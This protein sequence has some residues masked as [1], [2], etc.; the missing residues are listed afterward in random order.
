MALLVAFCALLAPNCSWGQAVQVGH[1]GIFDGLTIGVDKQTQTLSGFYSNG[2]GWDEMR[3]APTFTCAFYLYGKFAADKYNII[4]WYPG[5]TETIGGQLKYGLVDGQTTITIKLD[6]EHG[7]CPNVQP[8]AQGNGGMLFESK[9]GT[10]RAIRVVR[11]ERAHV[12]KKPKLG[13][14]KEGYV[15]YAILPFGSF[16]LKTAGL[17]SNLNVARRD[18][19]G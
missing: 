12:Y 6:R 14:K 7:G 4:T 18:A 11:V 16:G 1:S 9:R 2:S 3:K 13:A 8:F 15:M 5:E 19:D 17:R 10:W